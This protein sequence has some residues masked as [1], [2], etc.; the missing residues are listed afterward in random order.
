MSEEQQ[1]IIDEV[2]GLLDLSLD[3]DETEYDIIPGVMRLI[4]NAKQSAKL[5]ESAQ[6]LMIEA[7]AENKRMRDA[8]NNLSKLYDDKI[9]PYL[10]DRVL[11]D[12]DDEARQIRG[13]LISIIFQAGAK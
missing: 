1:I 2:M 10:T 12:N 7:Q 5:A 11:L 8:L 4:N 6:R 13:P 3:E 9:G